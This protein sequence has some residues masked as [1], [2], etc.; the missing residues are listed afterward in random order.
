M[1]DVPGRPLSPFHIPTPFA[2]ARI[3]SVAIR[4]PMRWGL[5]CLAALVLRAATSLHPYSGEGD[6]PLFGDYEAQRHWMEVTIELPPRLWY[7]DVTGNNLTYWGLD[8]PPLSGYASFVAGSLLRRIE[9]EAVEFVSSHG[10]ESQTSRAAM[11]ASVVAADVFVFF[12]AVLACIGAS[13]GRD[14]EAG[15]AV[16]PFLLSL[17]ALLLID[18]GH[19]QYNNVSLGL[20]VASVAAMGCDRHAAG[21]VLFCLSV[22]FKQMSLYYAP[23]VAVYLLS[24]MV[25]RYRLGGAPAMLSFAMRIALSIVGITYVIFLPWLPYDM[26]HVMQRLFPFARGLFE[27]KVANFWCTL[28]LFVKLHRILETHTLVSLC[29]CCTVV[30]CAPFCIALSRR[31]NVRLLSLASAGCA[32]SAFL[33]SYQVHEKQILIL[34]VPLGLLVDVLP[35][36]AFWAS[37][38]ATLSLYP[39]LCREGLGIAYIALITLHV[40][41]FYEIYTRLSLRGP[42]SPTTAIFVQ[43]L[44]LVATLIA[45]V[46]HALHAFGPRVDSKPDLYVVLMTSYTSAHLCA[47]YIALVYHSFTL[48]DRKPVNK[49]S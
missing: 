12:P 49:L 8:Y 28:S 33:F 11:R 22:Y 30:A 3:C 1:R 25:E 24:V 41:I 14:S 18:H 37:L 44:A 46:L 19:F 29:A 26:E 23:A 5:T 9:P 45:F 2:K 10:H 6:A 48:F 13:V 4:G 27:D 47:L 15:Q 32:L 39:L 7:R 38:V 21:A 40:L 43:I 20:F 36:T 35:K 42:S 34:L 17:P 16:L 31:P